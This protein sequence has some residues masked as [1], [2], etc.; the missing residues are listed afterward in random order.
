MSPESTI[1]LH[2]CVALLRTMP[3]VTEET[4]QAVMHYLGV[5]IEYSEAS[6]ERA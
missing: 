6:R 2:S 5:V 3:G 1:V 4:I